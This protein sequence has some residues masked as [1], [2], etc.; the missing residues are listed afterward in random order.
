MRTK[1]RNLREE[2]KVDSEKQT[3]GVMAAQKIV[4]R[5][6]D[7]GVRPDSMVVCFLPARMCRCGSG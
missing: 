3:V 2:E 6:L 4:N 1:G 7:F 5:G